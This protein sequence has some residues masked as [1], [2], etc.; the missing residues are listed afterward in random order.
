MSMD[1]LIERM[2]AL[3][4]PLQEAGDA[5]RFFHATYLRTTRAVHDALRAGLFS[6]PQWVERWDVAF[7]DRYLDALAADSGGRAVPEPWAV[8][9]RAAREQ[10]SAPALRHVLLGMNAHINYDLPQ[11]LLAVI[12][13]GEFADPAVTARRRADHQR[14][15]EVLSRQVGAEDAEL[16]RAGAPRSRTDVLLGPAN[17]AASRRFLRE[18]RAKVWHNAVALNAARVRDPAAYTER[19]GELEVLSA[20][21]V[22]ELVRPGQVLLRLASRGFGVRLPGTAGPAASGASSSAG[23]SRLRSFDPVRV[24]DLEFRAWVGYYRRDWPGVLRASVGLVRAGFGMDWQRSLHGAWLVLRANQLWAPADND[25]DGA[26][27]CMRRFYG[28]LRISYGEPRDVAEA[29]RR[30][31]DWW[32]VH[33]ERQHAAGQPDGDDEL[34]DSLV[35]LYTFLYGEPEAAVRPAA[36]YRTEA[37]DLSDQWV[38]EGCRPDSPLLAREHAALV[39]SYAALLAAV[40]H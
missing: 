2:E 28:L 22:A 1:A 13:P 9:F 26:R 18:A 40:H 25:P 34:V 12:S 35:R 17:Q 11:A 5:R 37:M 3:L 29:A 36:V 27:R 23:P 21:R 31:V 7:A 33:R 6:D 19:L 4:G 24:A 8:T 14:I 10:P 16:A 32:R 39:R 30:E 15:D 38:A 20:A